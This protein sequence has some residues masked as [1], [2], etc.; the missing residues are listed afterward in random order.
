MR[1]LFPLGSEARLR[2]QGRAGADDQ[3]ERPGVDHR[4]AGTADERPGDGPGARA[5]RPAR[6]GARAP[7]AAPTSPISS[8]ARPSS[9]ASSA[10]RLCS[11]D[12]PLGR[13]DPEAAADELIRRSLDAIDLQGRVL[14]A[15]HASALCPPACRARRRCRA[16]DP[17]PCWR[18]QGAT[19][20]AG[21]PF[22]CRPAAP[23]QGQ[24]RAGDGGARVPERA[25][26]WRPADRLRRQRRGHPLGRR[27]ARGGYAGRSRRW[28]R[29]ATAACWRRA[30]R[31]TPPQLRASL[32][33]WRSVAPL[34][35]AGVVRDWVSYPG[36]FAAG[37]IDEGTALLIGALPPL[38]R[39]DRVL[40]YGCGSGVIGAA[41]LAAAPDIVLDLLDDDAVAL[42][43]AR[44][45]VA[46][47]RF[48]LGARLADAAAHRLRRHPVQSAAAQGHCRGPCVARAAHR[49]RS[50]ASALR[51]LPA[52]RGAATHPAWTACCR[53]ISPRW[54]CRPRTDAIA[55]GGHASPSPRSSRGE[56]R[57]EGQRHTPEQACPSV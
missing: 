52:D 25:G 47:A 14:L 26:A 12:E 51:R 35:V 44:E 36:V 20:A 13:S 43:A 9:A 48:I 11:S 49:R 29:A 53:S 21:R 33:A 4:P 23:A 10:R 57:G 6:I 17:A 28:R 41:A 54:R 46:G 56:G 38:R 15:N 22:R 55:S 39:G 31:R 24:G 19:L 37:R 7:S 30:G 50:G 32:A 34:A 42:E 40:D 5:R 18:R 45:N 2:R 1:S 16:V 27:H 8:C 3:G